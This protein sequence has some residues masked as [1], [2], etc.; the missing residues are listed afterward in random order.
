MRLAVTVFLH[1]AIFSAP[2]ALRKPA[3][4][5]LYHLLQSKLYPMLNYVPDTKYPVLW[6]RNWHD[7]LL[8]E[9]STLEGEIPR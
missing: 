3:L 4:Q 1:G 9:N 6:E 7:L 8:P 5:R 2:L